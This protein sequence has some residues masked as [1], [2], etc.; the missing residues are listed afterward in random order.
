MDHP[1]PGGAKGRATATPAVALPAHY[2]P[3]IAAHAPGPF[4]TEQVV[5]PSDVKWLN[6]RTYIVRDADTHQ[7]YRALRILDASGHFLGYWAIELMPEPLDLGVRF[8][9][10]RQ[11]DIADHSAAQRQKER[12]ARRR[13][14]GRHHD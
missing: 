8:E 4:L 14:Y 9:D 7:E 2:T 10:D 5:T 3:A 6:A 13:R 1:S 12:D 11:A